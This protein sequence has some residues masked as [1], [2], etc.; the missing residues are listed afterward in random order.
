MK[1]KQSNDIFK[2]FF[3]S[4]RCVLFKTFIENKFLKVLN[5]HVEANSIENVMKTLFLSN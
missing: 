5:A 1:F 4:R 2:N 3:L